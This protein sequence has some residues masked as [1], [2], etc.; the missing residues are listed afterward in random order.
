MC[1][2]GCHW[3]LKVSAHIC[4]V[5]MY[6][7]VLWFVRVCSCHG[8][9]TRSEDSLCGVGS[10]LP[11]PGLWG[12]SQVVGAAGAV[13]AFLTEPSFQHHSPFLSLMYLLKEVSPLNILFSLVLPKMPFFPPW[14]SPPMPPAL[15]DLRIGLSGR[16]MVLTIYLT[17]E[18]NY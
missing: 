18:D 4:G 5:C 8:E 16:A 15:T 2:C 11:F 10:L 14:S 12:S 3:I 1:Y 13:T 6:L 9:P 17:L 7:C